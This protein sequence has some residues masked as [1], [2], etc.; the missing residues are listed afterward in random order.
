MFEDN[1]HNIRLTFN[2]RLKRAR[3]EFRVDECFKMRKPPRELFVR[4]EERFKEERSDGFIETYLIFQKRFEE[5]WSHLRSL[6]GD[7]DPARE[8]KF[9]IAQGGRVYSEI[10]VEV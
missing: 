7:I 2:S 5:L 8:I 1:R 9:T 3:L 4:I 6:E 10:Q